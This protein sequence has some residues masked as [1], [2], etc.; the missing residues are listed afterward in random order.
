MRLLVI[1]LFLLPPASAS[2]LARLLELAY[3][4]N[5][6]MKAAGFMVSREKSLLVAGVTPDDPML[7][8]A[9]LERRGVTRYGVLT[10]NLRF[11]LKYHWQYRIHKNRIERQKS[12]H[13]MKKFEVRG[14]VLSLY[15]S[16]YSMQNII[17]ITRANI[18]SLKES[19]R[20]A[21]KK[22]AS[23][24]S[25]QGDS[26]K[27]H[28]EL[29]RLELDLLNLIQEEEALQARLKS[30]V[31]SRQWTKLDF[32]HKTPPI[33][34]YRDKQETKSQEAPLLRKEFFM[35]QE[36]RVADTKARWEFLPDIQLQYQWRLSGEPM[37]SRIYSVKMV[38]PLWFWKKGTQA[39][40]AAAYKRAREY[41]FNHEE[42]KLN[43]QIRDLKGKAKTNAKA[44]KIYTTGLIPQAQGAYRLAKATYRANK[45]S[46]LNLLDSERS[47][48][49]VQTGFYRSL[50]AYVT[51]LVRLESV[52]G[53]VVSNWEEK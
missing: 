12:H 28:L 53:V 27:A 45:A 14:Q 34:R 13:R 11:P 39:A 4:N 9:N 37:D 5:S 50:T 48:Y 44:L 15:Y 24:Q 46:F 32:A 16:I 52:L 29:T 35:L 2:E 36:A 22:Y 20:I 49:R 42:Q 19:A 3:Q 47:L 40:A 8:F 33:P 26:M 10:Q 21:E 17:G 23:G 30:V 7:G 43:A 18:R 31:N 6:D 1:F 51:S 25:S 41:R 38:F